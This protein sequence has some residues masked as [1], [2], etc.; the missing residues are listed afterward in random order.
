MDQSDILAYI[1]L[2]YPINQA[3]KEEGEL[4]AKAATSIGFLGGEKIIRSLT[5]QFGLD[6]VKIQSSNTTKEASLVLGKYLSPKLYVQYAV[7]IGE[8]VNSMM[9]DYKVNK[10]ISIKSESGETQSTD[11]IFSIE[12]N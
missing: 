5:E 12:K 6:E 3:S 2:G 10:Q 9:L 11:I 8:T 4:L 1:V 7:G